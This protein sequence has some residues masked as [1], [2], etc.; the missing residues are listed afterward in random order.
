MKIKKFI[1][2][3][4]LAT[5]IVFTCACSK[6]DYTASTDNESLPLPSFT[7]DNSREESN[8]PPANITT[9]LMKEKYKIELK[10]YKLTKEAEVALLLQAELHGGKACPDDFFHLIFLLKKCH[11]GVIFYYYK[12]KRN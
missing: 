4:F 1:G 6:I 7:D 8:V 12:H 9:E 10:D 2:T 3:V 11:S 5:A